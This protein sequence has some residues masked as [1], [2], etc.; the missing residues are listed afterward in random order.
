MSGDDLI[1]EIERN[2]SVWI[3]SKALKFPLDKL[4]EKGIVN[5]KFSMERNAL[6]YN[7]DEGM[8]GL[9]RGP[10]F[11]RELFRKFFGLAGRFKVKEKGV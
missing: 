6:V 2:F 1:K 10:T 8:E 3:G 9:L 5:H 7:I 4:E 11:T